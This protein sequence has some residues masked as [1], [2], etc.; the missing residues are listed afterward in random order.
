M[1]L[2]VFVRRFQLYTN[3]EKEI[4]IAKDLCQAEKPEA[5]LDNI[6]KGNCS[7]L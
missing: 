4:E 5:M 3:G 2:C 1:S 6:A 7:F